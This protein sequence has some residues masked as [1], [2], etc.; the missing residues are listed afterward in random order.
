MNVR[1]RTSPCTSFHH[2]SISEAQTVQ[3]KGQGR[4]CAT[5]ITVY[6]DRFQQ[7]A[8]CSKKCRRNSRVGG[9][10]VLRIGTLT[11]VYSHE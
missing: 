7:S 6:Y 4:C 3:Y 2:H 11:T 8:R 5:F 1:K 9:G 10:A